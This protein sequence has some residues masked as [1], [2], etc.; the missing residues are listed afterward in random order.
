M[1][2]PRAPSEAQTRYEAF[3]ARHTNNWR[4]GGQIALA[5]LAVTAL[6][7][8]IISLTGG[9]VSLSS[10][11]A[12]THIGLGVSALAIIS[13]VHWKSTR[14]RTNQEKLLNSVISILALA[15]IVV[16]AAALMHH[17]RGMS[18]KFNAVASYATAIGSGFILALLII[19]QIKDA[20]ELI[21][22]RDDFYAV[23]RAQRRAQIRDGQPPL[24]AAPNVDG[25]RGGPS[26]LSDSANSQPLP[27]A[28]PALLTIPPPP[29]GP[30]LGEGSSPSPAPRPSIEPLAI[31]V[32]VGT[33]PSGAS[34]PGQLRSSKVEPVAIPVPIGT[35][36]SGA[37]LPGQLRSSR[38]EPVAIPV[39]VGISPSGANLQLR[40]SI[41]PPTSSPTPT[42]QPIDENRTERFGSALTTAAFGTPYSGA[43]PMA[44]ALPPPPGTSNVF[45]VPSPVPHQSSTGGPSA[46][47][48]PS[49]G[50]SETGGFGDNTVASGVALNDRRGGSGARLD[51]TGVNPIASSAATEEALDLV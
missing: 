1:I 5:G 50:A 47:A 15:L 19:K 34:L 25:S 2:D 22:A 7:L 32:P 39:P 40:S 4:V 14:D 24:S 33:S 9:T 41:A 31:P 51:V 12:Y 10:G 42:L 37:S 3:A 26:Q 29:S 16:G 13:V 17:Y 11:M 48:A 46:A 30:V 20:R 43:S 35:S 8:S 38:A 28:I 18:L 49:H 23:R 27:G 6:F 45:P 44:L 36:S 21:R